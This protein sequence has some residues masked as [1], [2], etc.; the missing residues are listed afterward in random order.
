MKYVAA[1][2]KPDDLAKRLRE[3]NI[4]PK[5]QGMTLA[6]FRGRLGP[7]LSQFL[8]RPTGKV[9]MMG[10]TNTGKTHTTCAILRKLSDEGVS[11]FWADAQ[12]AVQKILG[13]GDTWLEG[14]LRDARVVALD[15]VGREADAGVLERILRHRDL[16]NLPTLINTNLEFDTRTGKHPIEE[17]NPALWRRLSMLRPVKFSPSVSSHET[18]RQPASRENVGDRR[19]L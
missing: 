7:R 15:D 5:Y 3:A 1:M 10:P 17:G 18:R 13:E 16:Q 9:L 4:P 11:V 19:E 6:N 14:R 8:D 12:L 2:E